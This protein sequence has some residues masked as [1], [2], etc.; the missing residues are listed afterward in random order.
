MG[1]AAGI[2]RGLHRYLLDRTGHDSLFLYGRGKTDAPNTVKISSNLNTVLAG[3]TTRLLGSPWFLPLPAKLEKIVFKADI[4]HL[5]NLH[6]YYLDY[7][8]LFPMIRK[9][10]G[11]VVWTMHD[12]WAMTGRCATP[13]A[14][15]PEG[16]M[17]WLSG[18]GSCPHLGIY[19]KT[20][21]DRSARDWQRKKEV[22]NLLQEDRTILC[23]PS[24]WLK[25]RYEQS[26]LGHYDIRT[27]PNGIDFPKSEEIPVEI[28]RKSGLP[29]DKH[30]ILTV[31]RSMRD[32]EKGKNLLL[33]FAARLPDN[34]VLVCI[35]EKTRRLSRKN[36]VQ[37]G[38]IQDREQLARIYRACDVFVNP[39]LSDVFSLTTAEAI[40][41]GLPVIAFHT[42]GVPEVLEEG[43]GIVVERGNADRLLQ[44]TLEL[45]SNKQK[46]EEMGK[47]GIKRAN[48]LYTLDCMG[49]NYVALYEELFARSQK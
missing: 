49:Q 39:T 47:I 40:S 6:G 14:P 34:M 44:A 11:P 1:G 25:S 19:P 35:G 20:W 27:V 5:H 28:R 21:V 13:D 8:K 12:S 29:V 24:K 30:L 31:A 9:W 36:I 10:A 26:F 16:C 22:F 45:L 17:R 48:T 18:C 46:R 37:L 43:A 33:K 7:G 3:F 15:F 38:Y 23:C 41:Q 4:V 42:G 32:P 2:A